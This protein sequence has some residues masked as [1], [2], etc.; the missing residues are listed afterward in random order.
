ML[1]PPHT[2]ELFFVANG[3]G[4]HVF[5]A[6]LEEHNANVAKWR[7]VERSKA[8]GSGEAVPVGEGGESDPASIK[9]EP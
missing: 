1:D 7:N 5:A 3:K 8:K 4:G 9:A 2:D 6:T